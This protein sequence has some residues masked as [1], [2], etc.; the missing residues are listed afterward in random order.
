MRHEPK[1]DGLRGLAILL[2][3]F[4]HGGDRLGLAG[5]VGEV[6][7]TA[8]GM[9]WVGVDLFFVLSGYLI[10][11]ILLDTAGRPGWLTSFYAR[12]TLRI[13]PAYYAWLLL[14]LVVIPRIGWFDA[15]HSW[16][17]PEH[18]SSLWYWLYASNWAF[19]WN[20]AWLHP[21][22]SLTWS[23]AIEEQF[24]AV[25]PWVV[26]RVDAARL[27]RVCAVGVGVA[28]V[29]R[30]ALV[31]ADVH[32][33]AVFVMTPCRFDGL[34]AGAFI[35]CVSRAP[36]GREAL[37]RAARWL[38]PAAAA[39]LLAVVAAIRA[40]LTPLG[41]RGELAMAPAMQ[42][43]G[44][45][46]VALLFGA[47]LVRVAFGTARWTGAFANPLL[48]TFG[49]YSYALYLTHTF[50]GGFFV[51]FVFNPFGRPWWAA[52]AS[53]PLE[54]AAQLAVAMLSWVLLE[55]HFLRLKRRFAV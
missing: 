36:G 31:A 9:G 34:L 41:P 55:S 25:W 53:Y 32:P 54:W 42:T 22:L 15:F 20:A 7:R 30:V 40:G 16:R 23:L 27:A 11:G 29:L 5:P 18:V 46:A 43:V 12:R 28:L 50:V 35:A 13:F 3:V 26:R 24:Y 44:L 17:L 8:V 37:L 14:L 47:L 2:V 45:S 39:L 48:R 33:I 6:Y 1:L 38:L 4:S 19:A 51:I 10:T 49:K 52:L 21:I